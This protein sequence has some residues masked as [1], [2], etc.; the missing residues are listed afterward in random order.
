MNLQS[1]KVFIFAP[2]H[3]SDVPANPRCS[4]Q[5]PSSPAS[6]AANPANLEGRQNLNHIVHDMIA[7]Q[8]CLGLTQFIILEHNPS[9]IIVFI[10]QFEEANMSIKASTVTELTAIREQSGDLYHEFLR[11]PTMSAGLYQLAADQQ[12]PQQSHTEDELYYIVQ[13]HCAGARADPGS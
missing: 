6:Q 8:I 4:P 7:H 10:A 9:K 5:T 2:Q 13:V 1:L 3:A 12:D 11:V